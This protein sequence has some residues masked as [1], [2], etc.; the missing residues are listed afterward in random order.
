MAVQAHAA[1]AAG[2]IAREARSAAYDT[3]MKP[4]DES[5]ENDGS[6]DATLTPARVSGHGETITET[7]SGSPSPVPPSNSYR[8]GEL[9]GRG[10][11]GEVLLADD[12][13]IGRQVAVKRMRG[14]HPSAEAIDRFLREAKIQA[15]LD[16]P[17]IVPV[18]ELG[19]DPDGLPFFTM[20]RLSGTTLAAM[21]AA[22]TETQQR[23]LR[24][25]VDVCQA[26]GFAHARGVI[27]RDLKP[28]NIMLG[29]YGEVYVLD[30]GV[31]RVF[32]AGEA[33]RGGPRERTSIPDIE[34]LGGETQVGALLGT[35]GYMSPEQV[36]GEQITP[37][38]DVYALG[39]ILFEIL[40]GEPVH[41]A[42]HAALVSTLAGEPQEPTKR[43]PSRSIPPELDEACAHALAFEPA[44][45]PT[46]A[47]LADKVQRYLDGDRDLAQ[48]RALAVEQLELARAAVASGDPGRRAEAMQAAGRALGLDPKS[49][50]A[51]LIGQLVTQPPETLPAEIEQT[52]EEI[53]R[54]QVASHARFSSRAMMSYFAMFP[55]LVWMGVID[56]Q[57][58]ALM[59]AMVFFNIGLAT[60]LSR[61]GPGMIV[62]VITNALLIM[63]AGRIFGPFVF[64]PM[65]FTGVSVAW[66]SN[67]AM[68]QRPLFVIGTMVAAYLAPV[69]LE[70]AGLWTQTWDVVDH[71]FRVTSPVVHFEREGVGLFLVLAGSILLVVM[72][73]F[74]RSIAIA[75]RDARRAV[76]IQA[77]HLKQLLPRET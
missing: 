16:H 1:R 65:L 58:V 56:W 33:V 38:T 35:P 17:A 73:M 21:L 13:R 72:P 24:A 19:T 61:F 20:K 31:A 50:A 25:F 66:I 74:V 14:A 63:T 18:H 45:R 22:R 77:W 7:A 67:S 26:I 62:L 57:L 68:L 27:H 34:S 40:A 48:R 6:L 60:K 52:L 54:D 71:Q 47:T 49:E 44:D 37:A 43:A 5:T 70:A 9:L 39:A 11:M 64:V 23:F 4:E 46:A 75:Q 3:R 15:R 8:L 36:R 59:F 53:E 41:P 42:G 55:V 2:A 32:T 69:L 10:G 51:A 28:A 12:V 76:E 29:E 30:W